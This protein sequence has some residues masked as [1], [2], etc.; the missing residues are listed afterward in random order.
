MIC[1]QTSE[2]V[3]R[4]L[5]MEVDLRDRDLVPYERVAGCICMECINQE[6][7][8]INYYE[9]F[10]RLLSTIENFPYVLC[11]KTDEGVRMYKHE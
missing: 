1:N 6:K 10:Q 3:L 8:N 9:F 5:L 11:Y 4:P 2:D 7:A